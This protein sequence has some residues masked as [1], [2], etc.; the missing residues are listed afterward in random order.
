[1]NTYVRKGALLFAKLNGR[2]TID[3]NAMKKYYAVN[4]VFPLIGCLLKCDIMKRKV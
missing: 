1:M 3:L 2:R 4:V